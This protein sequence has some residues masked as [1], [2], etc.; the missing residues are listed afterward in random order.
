MN[1]SFIFANTSL[2]FVYYFNVII[3]KQFRMVLF[4]EFRNELA[5]NTGCQL[6]PRSLQ[7]AVTTELTR[8]LVVRLSVRRY[9]QAR[10]DFMTNIIIFTRKYGYR[11]PG[12][13]PVY[14]ASLIRG[15]R[16]SRTTG[17]TVDSVTAAMHH[18]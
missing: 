16:E 11:F 10:A 9:I 14:K 1:M 7:K 12:I 4:E 8:K 15:R 6:H 2:I 18:C 17:S 13:C 5:K 3:G